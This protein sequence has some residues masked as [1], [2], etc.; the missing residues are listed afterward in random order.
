MTLCYDMM[1][2]LNGDDGR[3]TGP[4]GGAAAAALAAS[5]FQNSD[6]EYDVMCL[7]NGDDSRA[8]ESGA[9]AAAL[10]VSA[11]Q[12]SDEDMATGAQRHFTWEAGGRWA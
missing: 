9:A 4:R 11:F 3:A 10:A 7:L 1:Y 6:D 8:F 5:T 2:L 12:N